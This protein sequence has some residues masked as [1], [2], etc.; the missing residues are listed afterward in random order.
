MTRL[1]GLASIIAMLAGCGLRTDPDFQP[2]CKDEGLV[3]DGGSE[4]AGTDDAT[5]DA[6]D[7]GPVG[8]PRLGSCE[9][10]IDMPVGETLIVRGNLGGCSGTEGWCGG[11]GGE[12]VYR[13]PSTS[14]DIFIDFLPQETN[15]NPVLR[16]V[17]GDPCAEATVVDS[18]VCADITNS[19]PGRGF[20]DQGG[21]ADQYFVIVDTE[22]GDAGDYAFQVRFGEDAFGADCE[23]AFEE[24]AI[25]LSAG[26]NFVWEANLEEKQGRLDSGCI[27]PGDDDV[28]ELILTGGGTLNAVVEV[29][30]GG[31]EFQP[32]A[33]IRTDCGTT[34]ELSCGATASASFGE[35]TNALLVVDQLGAARG[36]YRLTVTY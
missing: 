1:V 26:G 28:F 15:F 4:T 13:V 35:T 31:E 7:D 16:V 2:I 6:T 24:Q 19:V 12:D 8:T 10:P 3:A 21:D 11:S 18:E 25:E 23:G 17:R 22:L 32:I 5:D 9:N 33:S 34:T 27:A 36:R 30:E 29:L 14:E 20:Y